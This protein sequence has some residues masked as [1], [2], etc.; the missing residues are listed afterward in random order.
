ML[1]VQMFSGGRK[2]V[3]AP[4]LFDAHV[5]GPKVAAPGPPQS[6]K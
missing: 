6:I 3:D 2:N 1:D 4:Q 5:V